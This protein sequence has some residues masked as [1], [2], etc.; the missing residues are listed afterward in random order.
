MRAIVAS[1]RVAHYSQT[2]RGSVVISLL[3]VIAACRPAADA[4]RDP[5]SLFQSQLDALQREYEFPGATAAFVLADGRH[6]VVSTGFA[7][8]ESQ[9]PMNPSSRMLAAS[10]GKT[11]VSAT[12]LALAE[13][14]RL[15]LDDRLSKWLGDAPWL[16]RLADHDSITVRQLLSHTSGIPNHVE[17]PAFAADFA[18]R[19]AEHDNSFTPEALIEYVLDRP[20]LFAPGEGWSYTDT[21][22]ILLG[23]IVERVAERSYYE[24]VNDRF[25]IPLDL[26]LTS[27]SDRRDLAN[28]ATGYMNA[29]NQFELPART[30]DDN[31]LMRWNPAVEWTGGGLVSNSL[32]LARWAKLLFEGQALQGIYLDDLLRETPIDADGGDA[33]YGAGVSIYRSGQIGLSYG[34]SGWIPG[35]TSSLRYYPDHKAAVAFQINTDIGIV[36][37]STD[38]YEEM[39]SR[40]ERI[41]AGF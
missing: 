29:E 26:K 18:E 16:E 13:E 35:Y 9:S 34:H 32:D 24:E 28:L 5:S 11:F 21:G 2:V 38:L 36:D 27:P 10:I 14:G 7:D 39:A 40:F 17:D 15:S 19:W 33:S 31:G 30:T 12:V 8:T 6:G 25:L 3:T 23:L 20:L 41:V 1:G 22:Y 37:G 4:G